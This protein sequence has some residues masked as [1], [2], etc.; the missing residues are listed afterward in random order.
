MPVDIVLGAQF[1]DEGKGKLVDILTHKYELCARC[2]GGSNAG[3]TL[4]VDGHKFAFHLVP[5]GMLNRE[6]ICVV[7]NGVVVHFPT[8]FKE[9][10]NLKAG[11]FEDAPSRMRISDR[12][13]IVFNFNQ[14]ADGLREDGMGNQIGTT[15]KGI[16]PTYAAKMNRTGVRVGDLKFWDSFVTKCKATYQQMQKLYGPFEYD[17]EA[18]IQWFEEQRDFILSM[19]TDTVALM[20]RS[21]ASE[22]QIM[23]EG[24]NATMLDIDFGTYPYVTSSNP[25]IGGVITGLGVPPRAINEVYGVVKAYLT[26]VGC[27]PFPSELTDDI[28]EQL[29]SVGHEFGTTTGRPRRCGWI[30]IPQLRYSHGINGFS[31]LNLTKLD[32]M[33]G[34]K[35]IKICVDYKYKGEILDEVPSCLEIME[36]VEPVYETMSGWTEDISKCR[37]FDELPENCRAYVKRLEELVEVSIGWIGIGPGRE[38]MIVC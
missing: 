24:A 9:F 23:V 35:E 19:T 27:G 18:E 20:R 10:D 30:D 21:V 2:A 29:R 14:L 6:A 4:V 32:V 34:L 31:K 38:E 3:H 15:R 26:R 22:S 8:M 12:A 37:H 17:L 7:G 25:S 13:H 1:G 28:G 11:G 33:S 16:G 36:E 5:S